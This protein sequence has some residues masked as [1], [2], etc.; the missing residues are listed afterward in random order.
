MEVLSDDSRSAERY[1]QDQFS[2]FLPSSAQSWHISGYSKARSYSEILDQF[3]TEDDTKNLPR[4][5]KPITPSTLLVV[6]TVQVLSQKEQLFSKCV[7][8]CVCVWGGRSVKS[9][10]K[11]INHPGITSGVFSRYI[12]L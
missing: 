2:P 1:I 10:G 12:S 7:N 6:A 11:D 5:V 9:G 3:I 4:P 8:T